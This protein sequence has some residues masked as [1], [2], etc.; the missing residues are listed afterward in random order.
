MEN[1]RENRLK[2]AHLLIGKLTN[3]Q[4]KHMLLQVLA[5]DLTD[6]VIFE[7]TIMKIKKLYGEIK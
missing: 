5:Q 2:L 4:I 3:Q 6:N 7:E 1:N